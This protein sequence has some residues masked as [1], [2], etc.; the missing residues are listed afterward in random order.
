MIA[1]SPEV[2]LLLIFIIIAAV[3]LFFCLFNAILLYELWNRLRDLKI[4]YRE[5]RQITGLSEPAS[6]VFPGATHQRT[7]VE[8]SPGYP[9]VGLGL[10]R[11]SRTYHLDSLVVATLDG[12][13]VASSGSGDAEHDAAHYSATYTGRFGEPTPGVWVIPAE[14]RDVPLI[15]IARSSSV[16]SAVRLEDI[17]ADI[18]SIFSQDI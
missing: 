10:Q 4:S 2:Y 1:A 15:G 7:D 14:Y 5:H 9:D 16:L 12:L 13:V 8:S 17:A 11:L 3:S 18:R 6:D